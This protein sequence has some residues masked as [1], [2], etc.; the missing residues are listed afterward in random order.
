MS[1]SEHVS[2]VNKLLKCY[3]F[4][5]ETFVTNKKIQ[6]DVTTHTGKCTDKTNAIHTRL[7][8]QHSH[9]H[10]TRNSNT[11]LLQYNNPSTTNKTSPTHTQQ[12]RKGQKRHHTSNQHKR[13]QKQNRGTKNLVHNAQQDIIII[14]E[15]KLTQNFFF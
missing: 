8:M 14:Q 9:S 11:K 13:H 7:E 1:I 15:T 3:N 4:G 6:S 12:S 10:T 2:K 5:F